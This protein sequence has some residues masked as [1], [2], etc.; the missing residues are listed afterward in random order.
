M[1]AS[2]NQPAA[3]AGTPGIGGGTTPQA[4]HGEHLE[5][6]R[7]WIGCALDGIREMHQDEAVRQAVARRLF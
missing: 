2:D 1:N 5:I 4:R 7:E 6:V 3:D